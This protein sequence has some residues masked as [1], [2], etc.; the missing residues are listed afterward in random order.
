[1]AAVEVFCILSLLLFI[2]K[3]VRLAIPL[4]QKLYLPSSIIGGLIGLLVINCFPGFIPRETVAV[5]GKMPGFLINVIFASLFL[6]TV[7]PNLKEVVKM[8]MPQICMGQLLSWGQYAIGLGLAGF[9]FVPLFKVNPMFGNLL[10]IGFEGGHGTAGGMAQS[11]IN[12]GWEEGKDLAFTVATLGMIIGIIVGM[13][14]VNRALGKGVI[15]SVR[16]FRDRDKYEKLGIYEKGGA[17]SAGR[18][19]MLCDSVDSLAWHVALLGIAIAIGYAILQGLQKGETVLLPDVKTR[20]F[21]GFPLFPLCMIGGVILQKISQACKVDYL[22]CHEQMQ[23]L[24]GAS[25]DFLVLSAVATIKLGVVLA[26]WL[27]LLLLV[28]GGTVWSIFNVLWVAPRLFRTYWF[29]KAIAEFGQSTGV[30]ATGLLLLRTVDPENK[31]D[32]AAAFGYK[33][34]IHEPIMGGGLWTALALTL[35]YTMGWIKVFAISA[36]M[37]VIWGVVA[38]AII[39]QNRKSR[40]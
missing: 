17:P 12:Y 29:E 38:A 14:L 11:F 32:A 1:M 27:P 5:M 15:K 30:T 18:Q 37:L 13:V 2:G 7:T 28:I 33:Q 8:A 24:S 20:L 16:R 19:T 23:R 34:L 25:L 6:G 4:L 31:T 26:N 36:V 9:L 39:V 35:V 10:E 40:K 3:M 21:T 22:I